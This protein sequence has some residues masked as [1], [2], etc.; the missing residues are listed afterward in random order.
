[1]I[2]DVNSVMVQPGIVTAVV[3]STMSYQKYIDHCEVHTEKL[4]HDR[5][6]VLWLGLDLNRRIILYLLCYRK[7]LNHLLLQENNRPF[8]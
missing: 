3:L 5:S 8:W 6:D 2:C 7:V 1:M 4:N